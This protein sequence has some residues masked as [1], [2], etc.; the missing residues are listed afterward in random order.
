MKF[1][2]RAL[3]VAFGVMLAGG[4]L[5]LWQAAALAGIAGGY[6]ARERAYRS[7]ILGALG[8]WLLLLLVQLAATPAGRVAGA[9]GSAL[10][11]GAGLPVLFLASLVIGLL[12]SALGAAAGRSLKRT[13][14]KEGA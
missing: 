10:L 12:L 11:G 3:G 14:S 9:L 1:D 8:A 6:L 7:A 4:F 13:L 5:G 2:A